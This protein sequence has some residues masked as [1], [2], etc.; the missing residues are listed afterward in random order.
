LD[1]VDPQ[2]QFETKVT[3]WKIFIMVMN[4]DLSMHMRNGLA[5]KDEWGST[6]GK[7]KK[8]FNH[9]LKTSK[10]ESHCAMNQ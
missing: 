10:N 2:D 5:C 3:K 4:V 1:K 9:I 7:F 6:S 8:N